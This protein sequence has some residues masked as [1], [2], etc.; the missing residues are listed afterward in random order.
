MLTINTV[1]YNVIPYDT[2]RNLFVIAEFVI[3]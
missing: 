1:M 2:E 3:L